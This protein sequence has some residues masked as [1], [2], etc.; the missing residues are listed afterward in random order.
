MSRLVGHDV[1]DRYSYI[2]S[3]DDLVNAYLNMRNELGYPLMVDSK[4]RRAIVY[5]KKGLE[6]KVQ[7]IINETIINNI[8][9][10]DSAIVSDITNKLNSITQTANGTFAMGSSSNSALNVFASAMVKGVMKGFGEV[11]EDMNS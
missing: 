8:G 9:M 1:T 10:L 2:V 5:N 11:L 4:H 7:Q 3:R 6:K